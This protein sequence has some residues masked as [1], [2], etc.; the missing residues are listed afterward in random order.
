MSLLHLG[1]KKVL[2]NQDEENKPKKNKDGSFLVN[3]KI[4]YIVTPVDAKKKPKA[5]KFHHKH[6]KKPHWKKYHHRVLHHKHHRHHHHH[7]HH[8]HVLDASKHPLS[9]P[10]AP[11]NTQVQGESVEYDSMI[12]EIALD[13]CCDCQ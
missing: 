7:H 12:H 9:S 13:Y 6:A 3:F 1:A 10:P 11:Y 4:P 2:T 8:P 5:K